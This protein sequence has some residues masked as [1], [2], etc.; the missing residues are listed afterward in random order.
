MPRSRSFYAF[1]FHDSTTTTTGDG[2]DLCTAGTLVRFDTEADRDAWVNKGSPTPIGRL[3]M[4]RPFRL[5]V[6]SR[7]QH[8]WGS[9]TGWKTKDAIDVAELSHMVDRS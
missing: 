7:M 8:A 6:S 2:D 4:G 3:T 1:A 9:L 5:S